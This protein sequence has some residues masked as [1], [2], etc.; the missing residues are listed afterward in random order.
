MT[1]RCGTHWCWV[2]RG[3]FERT[4]IYEHLM[5][6]HGGIGLPGEGVREGNRMLQE[7]QEQRRVERERENRLAEIHR[8]RQNRLAEAHRGRQ[9]R[10][11]EVHRETQN[12]LAEAHRE[13]QRELAEQAARR[14]EA[15]KDDNW[16]AIM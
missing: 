3:V 9:N 10:L 12:R 1:C 11:A 6:A 13:R 14:A 8:E 16:C 7:V 4:T 2:C 15:Q 5:A